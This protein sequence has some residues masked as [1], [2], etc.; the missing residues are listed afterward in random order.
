VWPTSAA[1]RRDPGG[2]GRKEF[3]PLSAGN[4]VPGSGTPVPAGALANPMPSSPARAPFDGNAFSVVSSIGGYTVRVTTPDP[5]GEPLRR[6]IEAVGWVPSVG[7][8]N[9]HRRLVMTVQALPDLVLNAPCALC[10]RGDLDVQGNSLVDARTDGLCGGTVQKYGAYSAVIAVILAACG[11]PGPRTQA[12]RDIADEAL[13]TFERGDWAFAPG[14][15]G[16]LRTHRHGLGGYDSPASAV[17]ARSVG[18][19]EALTFSSSRVLTAA[20]APQDSG[21]PIAARLGMRVHVFDRLA[22][23]REKGFPEA[24]F[25]GWGAQKAPW[26][27]HLR[28]RLVFTGF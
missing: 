8:L 19:A 18:C 5:A 1:R 28:G 12:E 24:E 3:P 17:L 6:Q 4:V 10:V 11:G 21:E 23:L 13:A 27:S 26:A 9:A 16:D 7:P 2:R 15:H 20:D 14:L 25:L 22:Y